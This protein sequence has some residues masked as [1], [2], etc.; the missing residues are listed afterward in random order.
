LEKPRLVRLVKKFT[1]TKMCGNWVTREMFVP[2]R[3]DVGRGVAACVVHSTS[4]G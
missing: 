2:E 4:L 3:K 1:D